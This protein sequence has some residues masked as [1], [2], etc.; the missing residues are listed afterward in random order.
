MTTITAVI[1]Q[2]LD[3]K[4]L[5]SIKYKDSSGEITERV[6]RPLEWDA[7][8][9]LRAYC[10][11]RQGERQ[12]SVS[13]ILKCDVVE[14]TNK[15]YSP[16]PLINEQERRKRI[17][18]LENK[19]AYG[20]TPDEVE[21]YKVL[22][23]GEKYIR[24]TQTAN[25][26]D[27]MGNPMSW[28][29][30]LS[31]P[32]A[33]NTEKNWSSSNTSPKL[34]EKPPFQNVQT[35]EHW[36]RLVSYYRDCLI[37]ENRQQYLLKNASQSV[38]FFFLPAHQLYEFID[39]TTDLEF[40]LREPSE[41]EQRN[42]ETTLLG[43]LQKRKPRSEQ[44]LCIGFPLLVLEKDVVAPLILTTVNIERSVEQLR[45]KA[46]ESEPSYAALKQLNF[47]DEE[48]GSLLGD[49]DKVEPKGNQTKAEAIQEY[50]IS[51]LAE[52]RGQP[53]QEVASNNRQP[54][55]IPNTIYR[56]PCLFW[57]QP[58][59]A[60]SSLIAELNELSSLSNWPS[61][62]LPL[63]Q[64]LST[65]PTH[66]YPPLL[67]ILEDPTVYVAPA[68]DSQRRSIYAALSEP[69]TIVTGPPGTGKSQF[70]LNLI[71]QCTLRGERVLFA[72]HNNKAVDVVMSRLTTEVGFL[73]A[74]RTGSK[75]HRAKAA[76]HMEQALNQISIAGTLHPISSLRERFIELKKHLLTL[77]E[78]LAHV[79]DKQGLARSLSAERDDLIKVL[80]KKIVELA[81]SCAPPY[82]HDEL[83]H[84]QSVIANLRLTALKLRDE[85]DQLTH[86]FTKLIRENTIHSQSIEALRQFE[87]QWGSFGNRFLSPSD[88]DTLERL[89][90]YINIW[91]MLLPA[92]E[93]RANVSFLFSTLHQLR[94]SFDQSRARLS[95]TVLVDA[96]NV[97]SKLD[98]IR[99]A[100]LAEQAERIYQQANRIAQQPTT[101]VLKLLAWRNVST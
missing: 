24:Q 73:G 13:R 37:R 5:L 17:W 82:N 34:S 88:L 85:Q 90:E 53:F 83:T 77:E 36:Q 49:C 89:D 47:S 54:R 56:G 81:E 91:S 20:K 84:L 45:L 19:D 66:D 78:T 80:P 40:D 32:R 97:V 22:M 67:S 58:S 11:L 87:N 31:A 44:Q 42:S 60:T 69:A 2:A 76:A 28:Q 30:S 92:L 93:G 59:T 4:K 63:K 9:K 15:A 43:F 16:D 71:S 99:L 35:G 3:Q 27:S 70:I 7:P 51:R 61:A 21:E 72:S 96:E 38:H 48:I 41:S 79:R 23:R 101:F 8:Y 12:F 6:I 29:P 100:A 86:E 18:E 75:E 68:N 26:P 64:M 25:L 50:L 74:V 33:I 62:P 39:G 94:E 46:E 98:I 1:N 95:E 10:Y 52:L 57:I 65:L 14:S 55:L